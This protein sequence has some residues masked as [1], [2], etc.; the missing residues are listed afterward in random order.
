[1]YRT[2]TQAAL[3]AALATFAFAQTPQSTPSPNA[4]ADPAAAV[5]TQATPSDTA[6]SFRGI[7]MDASCQA[8][9][10]RESSSNSQTSSLS[11]ESTRSRTVPATRGTEESAATAHA[12][13]VG[14]AAS[15]TASGA[16]ASGSLNNTTN[17][18]GT[19][20]N[21][22]TTTATTGV[23]KDQAGEATATAT[24]TPPA[25]AR[26]TASASEP[27]ARRRTSVAT[28]TEKTETAATARTTTTPEA[29]TT[30]SAATSTDSSAT[31]TG[32][33]SRSTDT[34]GAGGQWTTVRDKYKDCKVTSSTS[35][36]AL[37]SNGQLYMIDDP[38]GTLRQQASSNTG[39]DWHSVTV[40][41]NMQG[42]HISVSSVK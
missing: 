24:A 8:I 32:E 22:A 3:S 40:M 14:G 37:M 33:R 38:D 11:T 25:D 1:M 12:T 13:G 28:E 4:P 19:A 5:N 17:S 34:T 30:E 31:A 9:Q 26:T 6:Q 10:N 41:G 39:S 20:G 35:S 29:T 23:A 42:D 15:A 16:G 27:A 18:G 21:S 2:L 7:L 36:F